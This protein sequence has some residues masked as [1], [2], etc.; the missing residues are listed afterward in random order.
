MDLKIAEDSSPA[1]ESKY[2]P[3][4]V[5]DVFSDNQAGSLF[6]PGVYRVSEPAQTNLFG[7]WT[8]IAPVRKWMDEGRGR[9][10]WAEIAPYSPATK[11]YWSE[12]K[13]HYQKN[14]VLL[15]KF[16]CTDGHSHVSRPGTT[17]TI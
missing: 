4:G 9:P 5:E 17:G 3:V 6:C 14:R 13:R 10:P 7:G 11:A 2:L 15:R 1:V 16:Y 12:W 8:Y